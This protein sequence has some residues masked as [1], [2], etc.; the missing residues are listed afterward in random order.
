MMELFSFL[1]RYDVRFKSVPLFT[2]LDKDRNVSG[3]FTRSQGVPGVNGPETLV[4]SK[5]SGSNMK[6]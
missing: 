1:D 4:N 3:S 2:D 5:W 6:K